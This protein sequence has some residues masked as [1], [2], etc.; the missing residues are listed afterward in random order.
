[1]SHVLLLLSVL[2][3]CNVRSPSDVAIYST[4][5]SGV[6]SPADQLSSAERPETTFH[7]P[8]TTMDAAD[9]VGEM[10]SQHKQRE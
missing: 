5:P 6:A 3:S 1:M 10:T 7:M 2:V 9:C 4:E 8:A